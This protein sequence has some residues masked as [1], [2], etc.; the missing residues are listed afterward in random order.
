MKKIENY[1]P[2]FPARYL[3][4]WVIV[5]FFCLPD[6]GAEGLT[7]LDCLIK[8]EMYV[9]LS[10][11]V[12]GV[13]ESVLVDKSDVVK[14]GQAVANLESAIETAVVALARQKASTNDEIR[15]KQ[16]HLAFTQRKLVRLQKLFKKNAISFNDQDEADTEAAMAAMAL[17]KAKSDKKIV[18]LQLQL[19]LAEL[20]QKTVR[21]PISGVV[22]ERLLMPGES[23]DNQPI[24]RLA[25]IDPLR[26]EV[27][28]PTEL[29]GRI[30][31]GMSAEIVPEA[32]ADS[33]YQAKVSVV[34]KI[35]D[36]ASGSFMVRLELPNSDYRVVGGLKCKIRFL[37]ENQTAGEI[38]PISATETESKIQIDRNSTAICRGTIKPLL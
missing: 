27:I 1:R 18:Q 24:L 28:A 12:D 23:V 4:I 34:D 15:S 10:S 35:I 3:T 21:S 30:K 31:K 20:E 38:D 5:G 8:P 17:E 11:S 25:Q 9:D 26:V 29:F 7:N 36:A 33:V 19:A 32:P 37:A 6:L 2:S 13:L 14:K 16:I 22:V